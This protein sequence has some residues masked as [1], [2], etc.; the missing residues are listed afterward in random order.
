LGEAYVNDAFG[1]SHR[2][3]ASVEA[4][5]R[6][7]TQSAAGFLLEAEIQNLGR[8]LENPP[9]PFVAVI[10]GAKLETK[11]AVIRNLLKTADF[12]LAGGGL[13]YTFFK[14]QGM[15]VGTSLVDDALLDTASEIMAF[16]EENGGRLLLPEDHVTAP[17]LAPG[18]P[19][20][21]SAVNVID[22]MWGGYDIGPETV[23][24]YC[25]KLASAGSIFW[26][27][28]MGVIETAPFHEGTETL[29]RAVAGSR[30]KHKVAG[31]GETLSAIHSLGL[32]NRFTHLSTG[33]GASLEFI[34]G[35]E[36]PGI[37]ALR[38]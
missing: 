1:V 16:S 18:A 14:A 33:G 20:R 37:K 31:G 24:M 7:I 23:D 26:N 2:A 35:D 8:L 9:R 3:H 17:Q 6:K 27:G 38:A 36:L 29:A 32:G 21:V 15:A 19:M 4:V 11:V 13:V 5:T 12:V 10:G 28:P 34:A 22:P 30:A 25:E